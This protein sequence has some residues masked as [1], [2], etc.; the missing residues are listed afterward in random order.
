M[1]GEMEH[2]VEE[3]GEGPSGKEDWAHPDR[4]CHFLHGW[5]LLHFPDTSLCWCQQ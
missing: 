3:E 2:E 5:H 4:R 1:E